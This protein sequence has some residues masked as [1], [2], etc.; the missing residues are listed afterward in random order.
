[1]PVM[2]T[3][4]QVCAAQEVCRS[5][6]PMGRRARLWD[7][8]STQANELEMVPLGRTHPIGMFVSFAH[9]DVAPAPQA[10]TIGQQRAQEATTITMATIAIGNSHVRQRQLPMTPA[11]STSRYPPSSNT[12][13]K[14]K[15]T[16]TS[17]EQGR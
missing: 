10:A 3:P 2:L 5:V 15:K 17:I 1:M 12:K 9:I 14:K 8:S 16:S 7:L 4:N 11:Y 13:D 6:S